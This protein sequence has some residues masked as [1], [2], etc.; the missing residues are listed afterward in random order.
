MACNQ[1]KLKNTHCRR[2][3]VITSVDNNPENFAT[4]GCRHQWA[5]QEWRLEV[6]SGVRNPQKNSQEIPLRLGKNLIDVK[7]Y[8]PRP[9]DFGI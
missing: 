6:G 2:H 7:G 9:R 5:Q 3:V 1:I 8:E 4:A